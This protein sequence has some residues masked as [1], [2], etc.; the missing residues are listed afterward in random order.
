VALVY[1]WNALWLEIL[2]TNLKSHETG[3]SVTS[4]KGRN[5]FEDL[6]ILGNMLLLIWCDVF[7]HWNDLPQ[8]KV[9]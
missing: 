7:V 5:C 6:G 4:V 1:K 9:Q 3:T 2:S 8:D